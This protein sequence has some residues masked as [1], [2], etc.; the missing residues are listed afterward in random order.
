LKQLSRP[1]RIFLKIRAAER[2]QGELASPPG[3]R[4]KAK[5]L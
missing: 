1:A 5:M 2:L 4:S 3:N